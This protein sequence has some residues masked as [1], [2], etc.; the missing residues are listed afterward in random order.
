MKIFGFFLLVVFLSAAPSIY[1]QKALHADGAAQKAKSWEERAFQA[2]REK[3]WCDA[4]LDFLQANMLV[5]SL[6]MQHNAARAAEKAQDMELAQAIYQAI[7]DQNIDQVKAQ[8]AAAQ[9]QVIRQQ[10]TKLQ[11]RSS[12]SL[13]AHLLPKAKVEEPVKADLPKD[14]GT[15]TGTG[16]NTSDDSL[17]RGPEPAPM[18]IAPKT[19][20]DPMRKA[21]LGL[22]VGGGILTA[23]SS[24]GLIVGLPIYAEHREAK[25]LVASFAGRKFSELS[26][27]EKATVSSAEERQKNALALWDGYGRLS[28]GFGAVGCVLGSAALITGVVLFATHPADPTELTEPEEVSVP[29][30]ETTTTP[31][32]NIITNRGFGL[33]HLPFCLSLYLI[34]FFHPAIHSAYFIQKEQIFTTLFC[35][36]LH[37]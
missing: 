36:I 21:G 4:A 31:C 24:V 8:N 12:C 10:E 3:H 15:G 1:A 37:I 23:A 11:K 32:W 29:V 34:P 28:T 20:G 9:L 7:A 14:T 25:N 2:V 18:I 35:R 5:P 13:P 22:M 26:D 30:E 6:D 16:T 17:R 33:K 27:G 19:E